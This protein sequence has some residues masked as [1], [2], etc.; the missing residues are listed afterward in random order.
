MLEFCA[1]HDVELLIA[2]CPVED[3]AATQALTATDFLLLDTLVYYERDLPASPVEESVT[4]SIEEIRP[5]DPEQVE[6]IARECFRDYLGHYHADRRLDRDACTEVY[7]SWARSA[8]DSVGPDAFVLV[9]GEPGK[10]VGFSTFRR[11]ADGTGELVLGAVLPA[12]RGRGLYRLL[13]LAGME[14][15]GSSG[16]TRFITSTHLSNWGAQASWVAA[17]LRPTRA[18]H[19]FHRWFERSQRPLR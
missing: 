17:G 13:T 14:R 12:A 11:S 5:G 7:A 18:Y 2:R 16:A 8:C 9:G 4:D 1:A 6:S 15:L 19:T 3:V 10:R